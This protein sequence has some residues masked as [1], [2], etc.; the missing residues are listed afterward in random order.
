MLKET[1]QTCYRQEL[2][3]PEVVKRLLQESVDYYYNDLVR[4]EI[5]YYL[6]KGKPEVF[7]HEFLYSNVA[8]LYN[9]DKLKTA[10]S[11]VQSGQIKYSQFLEQISQAGVV[12]YF[13]FLKDKKVVYFSSLGD[14][15]SERFP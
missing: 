9:L 7:P 3:F 14:S 6:S 1:I 13:A 15:Y 12:G 11:A 5:V 4:G 2:P 10:L 8:P